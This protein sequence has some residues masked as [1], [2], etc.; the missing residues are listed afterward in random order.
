F[1]VSYKQKKYRVRGLDELK[2]D[3]DSLSEWYKKSVQRVFLAD[4]NALAMQTSDLIEMLDLLNDE[5]PELKRVGVY[6]YAKDLREKT[7]E[8]LVTLK[9]NKLGIVYLG[10]ETGDDDLLRWIHK[11]V[12]SAENIEACSKIRSAGIPLSLTIILGLGGYPNTESHARKTAQVLN[13]IDPE[14]VGALTLMTPSGTQINDMVNSGEFV[15]MK[16][17]D[18]LK[19]LRLLIKYFDLTN[20]IFRTNHASNY[21]ALGGTLPY[22]KTRILSVLE[23]AITTNIESSLR[24]SYSRKL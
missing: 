20:C 3:L 23:N 17:M 21:I 8:D 12:D 10:L 22:D 14:Y 4:G 19:E 1:C 16:P 24:P 15:P 7:T 2:E 5:L 11:G 13:K 6:G 18:I 9:A